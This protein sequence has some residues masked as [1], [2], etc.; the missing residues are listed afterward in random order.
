LIINLTYSK[1]SENVVEVMFHS[2]NNDWFVVLFPL[3]DFEFEK[4][5]N[6]YIGKDFYK[7]KED[8]SKCI[9]EEDGY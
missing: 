8:Y 5:K 3:V 2:I 6:Y 1:Y 7:V 9:F 4:M